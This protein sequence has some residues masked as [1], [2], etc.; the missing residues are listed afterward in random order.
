MA[1]N[2]MQFRERYREVVLWPAW[3]QGLGVLALVGMLAALAIP[4]TSGDEG[5]LF[6]A[7][8][9]P[10]MGLTTVVTLTVVVNFR[11]LTI[12][13]TDE[14]ARFRFG[15]FG[16]SLPLEA[17]QSC[18]VRRYRWFRYGGWGLRMASGGRMAYS[19]L[20][21]PRGVEIT[22]ETKGKL[23]RY[24]VS[25]GRPEALAAALGR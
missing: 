17:V 2:D 11:Y 5:W 13:V 19:V 7:W 24:F 22:A 23:R 21:V 15:I 10:V 14:R 20:G 25:S 6:Y 12:E 3:M 9:Y 4:A 16:T 1:T 18:E 8:Y